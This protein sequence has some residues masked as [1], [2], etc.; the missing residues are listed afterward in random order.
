MDADTLK[1]EVR[2][3]ILEIAE[4][5]TLEDDKALRELGVDSMVALEII[6]AIERKYGVKVEE[7]ELTQIKTLS[8][9]TRLLQGKLAARG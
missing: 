8:T 3:L 6:T 7:S 5:A 4:L 2:E 9:I 1:A